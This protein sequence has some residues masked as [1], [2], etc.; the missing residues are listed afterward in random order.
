MQCC[1][2]GPAFEQ[3]LAQADASVVQAIMSSVAVFARMRAVQKG[4]VMGLLGHRGLH[5][6]VQGEQRHLPVST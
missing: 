5:N 4:Q 3:M 2:T 1:M 6:T